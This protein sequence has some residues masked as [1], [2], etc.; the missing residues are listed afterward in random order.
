MLIGV[1]HQITERN[2]EAVLRVYGQELND[3]T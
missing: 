2:P 1:L 3:E